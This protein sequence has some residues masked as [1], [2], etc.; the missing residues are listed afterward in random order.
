[1]KKIKNKN[2][3]EKTKKRENLTKADLVLSEYKNNKSDIPYE[4]LSVIPSKNKPKYDSYLQLVNACKN[5]RLLETNM[6][7]KQYGENHA[8]QYLYAFKKIND[9]RDFW[10]RDLDTWKCKSHNQT[11]QFS[12]L[13][14]HLFAKYDIPLFMDSVWFMRENWF[15]WFIEV[16]QGV[17]IRKVHDFPIKNYTKRMAHIMMNS[18]KKFTIQEAIRWGELCALNGDIKLFNALK[19]FNGYFDRLSNISIP[20]YD[21]QIIQ[22]FINQHMLDYTQVAPLMDFIYRLYRRQIYINGERIEN[23]SLKGR[24]ANRMIYLMNIWHNDLAKIKQNKYDEW[25][26]HKIDWKYQLGKNEN[27]RYWVFQEITNSKKL[28]KEGHIMKH[29]VYSYCSSC[30][31]G[32]SGIFNLSCNGESKLTIEVRF[33]EKN[34]CQ[35]RGK[36]NRNPTDDEIRIINRWRIEKKLY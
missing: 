1:M 18:P 12:S 19:G 3:I 23:F 8:N 16:G 6:V 14:R 35:I 31:S 27:T 4:F 30:V 21:R 10:I 22:W 24:D 13:V 34:V 36:C 26:S 28:Q 9:M 25:D 33:P 32:N 5:T 7:I 15:E 20:E 17:N 11:R 2:L 29:C